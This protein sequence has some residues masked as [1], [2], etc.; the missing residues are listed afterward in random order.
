MSAAQHVQESA[1]RLLSALRA[2]HANMLAQDL[3]N[4]LQRPT[5]REY[6]QCMHEAETAIRE[7]DA[8]VALSE[9][10]HFDPQLSDPAWSEA[11]TIA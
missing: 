5:E 8:L 2:L 4:E 9:R 3:A 6:E 10:V 1:P 11:P 7:A